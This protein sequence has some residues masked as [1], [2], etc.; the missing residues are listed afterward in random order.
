MNRKWWKFLFLLPISVCTLYAGGYAAQFIKNY[1]EWTSAGNFAGN[2]T[3][4]QAASLHPLVCFHTALTDFPYNLYGIFLCLVLF[5]L[6]TFLLMRMGYLRCSTLSRKVFLSSIASTLALISNPFP[7]N[8]GKP[9]CI[10][11]AATS[12]HS[13]VSTTA[14]SDGWMSCPCSMMQP[15]YRFPGQEGRI[16]IYMKNHFFQTHVLLLY[17]PLYRTYVLKSRD[18]IF[19]IHA[20]SIYSN[21]LLRLNNI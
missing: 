7:W 21:F 4:P 11:L 1:Q 10:C 14:D 19:H 15:I 6:L 12:L 3:Y 5:G 18:N 2:G 16:Y 20:F 9:H 8:L 13:F 17:I